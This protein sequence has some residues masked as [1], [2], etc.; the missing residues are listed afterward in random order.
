[1]YSPKEL[2]ISFFKSGFGGAVLPLFRGEKFYDEE[3]RKVRQKELAEKYDRYYPE[4]AGDE[5]VAD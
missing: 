4:G 5:P 2:N 1:V 3:Y